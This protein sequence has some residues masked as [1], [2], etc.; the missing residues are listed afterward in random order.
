ME[1]LQTGRVVFTAEEIATRVRELGA[2]INRDFAGQDLILISVLKG[3]MYF[4]AD[5]SRA[6][7]LP[8]ALDFITIGTYPHATERQGIVRITRD[9]DLEITDKP[10]LVVED[11]IRTGLTTAYLV[12]TLTARQ[13][14]RIQVCTLLS[15]PDQQMIHVPIAYCG[16]EISH[17]RLIGY[18]MDIDERGRN[19]PYIAEV[20]R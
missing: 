8:I 16:F 5:L 2:Q 10:V 14:A 20:V 4:F 15:C 3:S 9:L 19:L 11:I 18:G 12:Q 13:P 17:T 6:I 7:D 1:A